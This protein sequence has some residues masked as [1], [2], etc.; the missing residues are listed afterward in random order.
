MQMILNFNTVTVPP[1]E[2]PVER[3]RKKA[4]KKALTED[5]GADVLRKTPC[6]AHVSG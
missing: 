6:S 1:V 2:R 3:E 4:V 5:A